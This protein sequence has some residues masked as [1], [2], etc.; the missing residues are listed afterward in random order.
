MNQTASGTAPGQ[1][2]KISETAEGAQALWREAKDVVSQVADQASEKLK[3]EIDS[4]KDMAAG[5]AS[6]V[7]SAL[8]ESKETLGDAGPLPDL[9]DQAA[10]QIDKFANYVQTRNIGDLV[11]EVE[12]FA[13]RE[14][15][16]FL[17]ASLVAGLLGGRFLKASA[18]RPFDPFAAERARLERHYGPQSRANQIE[19]RTP[20]PM[21]TAATEASPPTGTDKPNGKASDGVKQPEQ[22]AA[23]KPATS[24]TAAG[25]PT[26]SEQNGDRNGFTAK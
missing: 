11:R 12:R 17:G 16:I 26:R 7:A 10:A 18:N 2:P 4:K 13:R 20:E 23:V 14:P 5:K 15:A 25:V 9:A 21:R 8:R 22:K 1:P 24:S 19:V 6:N 3:S